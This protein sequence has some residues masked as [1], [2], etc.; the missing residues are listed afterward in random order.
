MI[1]TSSAPGKVV[2]SGE[3]AVLEGAPALVMAVNRRC[4]VRLS[5]NGTGWRFVSHGFEARAH[6]TKA[7]LLSGPTLPSEDPAALAQCIFTAARLEA[8]PDHLSVMLD[9]SAAYDAGK[10]LGIGSSAAVCVALAGALVALAGS[11]DSLAIAIAAHRAFQ[12]GR[13]SGLDVATAHL[14]GLVRFEHGTGIR[15]HWPAHV[16]HCFVF[17]G[18]ST[19]T[20]DQLAKYARARAVAAGVDATNVLC[21][22]ARAVAGA[23]DARFVRELRDYAD[24]LADF[25]RVMDLGIYSKPHRDVAT[26]AASH[27]VVYKPCGAGGGDVGVCVAEDTDAVARFAEAV[28]NAGYRI[29]DLELDDNGIL[30]DI[31]R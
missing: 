6:H 17:T 7:E 23:P 14:G 25:D 3:Y 26:L 10:K 1:V 11:G 16:H 20:A 5:T 15:R 18:I 9:S 30:V 12:G 31:A 24:A 21:A 19:P 2:I 4:T 8:L 27:G 22:A 28:V 13:G 29:I